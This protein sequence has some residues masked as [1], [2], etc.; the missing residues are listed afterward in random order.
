MF[1]PAAFALTLPP[2]ALTLPPCSFVSCYGASKRAPVV[3]ASGPPSL[4]LSKER[5]YERKVACFL[6]ACRAAPRCCPRSTSSTCRACSS[7]TT[8]TPA[9]SWPGGCACRWELGAACRRHDRRLT[10]RRSFRLCGCTPRP[11]VVLGMP[12]ALL[13]TSAAHHLSCRH[14]LPCR[15]IH[16]APWSQHKQICSCVRPQ[17]QAG[18]RLDPRDC[19]VSVAA[20]QNHTGYRYYRLLGFKD[21]PRC[22]QE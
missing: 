16:T 20:Y 14:H 4:S 5:N 2:F 8:T 9:P 12:L 18:D 19:R 13:H 15:H 10:D 21:V 17:V 3:P 22:G 7:R 11:V 1:R 6:R